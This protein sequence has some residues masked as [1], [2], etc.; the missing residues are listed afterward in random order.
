VCCRGL[1]FVEVDPELLATRIVGDLAV[2]KRRDYIAVGKR[3]E[4]YT[5]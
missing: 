1:G 5:I 3:T 4:D 2:G